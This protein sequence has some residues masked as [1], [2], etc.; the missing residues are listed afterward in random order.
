MPPEFASEE[1][2]FDMG[3]MESVLDMPSWVIVSF[4]EV[5]PDATVITPIRDNVDVLADIE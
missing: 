2:L 3:E 4:F 5:V 1:K